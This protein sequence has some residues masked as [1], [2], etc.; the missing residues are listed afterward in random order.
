[1]TARRILLAASLPFALIAAAAAQV[2]ATS[3]IP[4]M[5]RQCVL[6]HPFRA[7]LVMAMVG[8]GETRTGEAKK[9]PT[10]IG[11]PGE[12]IRDSEGRQKIVMRVTIDGAKEPLVVIMMFAPPEGKV[13]M[14]MPS[15]KL[16]KTQ[17]LP[18]VH[19][20]PV[21]TEPDFSGITKQGGTVTPLG[22]REAGEL[23]AT[24][25][26]IE[27]EVPGKD[28]KPQKVEMDFW[29][30]LAQVIPVSVTAKSGTAFSMDMEFTNVKLVEP[31]PDEFKVPEGYREMTMPDMSGPSATPD[32]KAVT[33]SSAAP[34]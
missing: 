21:P 10:E 15:A 34:Q 20:G 5:D 4:G 1:M 16:M 3:P 11:I 8:R 6:N 23:R 12:I 28:S 14:L 13:R 33:P 30:D 9:A 27:T 19:C 26:R 25:Y 17:E 18:Q 7:D 31:S 29:T 2:G 24:G 32:S 22:T